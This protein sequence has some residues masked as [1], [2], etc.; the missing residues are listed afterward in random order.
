[1]HIRRVFH[2]QNALL[3]EAVA[4]TTNHLTFGS[5]ASGLDP[6]EKFC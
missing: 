3:E 6:V 1:M 5:Q 2:Y 4:L